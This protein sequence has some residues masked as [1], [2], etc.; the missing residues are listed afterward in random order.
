[1]QRQIH[2]ETDTHRDRYTHRQIHA[3]TDTCRDRY[4][5][6][7]I[8][9]RYTQRQKKMMRDLKSQGYPEKKVNIVGVIFFVKMRS[10]FF[11]DLFAS[12]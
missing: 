1:M 3:E 11:A 2:V 12:K 5:Q 8:S 7:Q 10:P 6:R 4:T 9:D